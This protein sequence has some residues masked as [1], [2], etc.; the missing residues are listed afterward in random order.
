MKFLRPRSI[1]C[2][3][4][5]LLAGLFMPGAKAQSGSP[6]VFA[7]ASLK[8]ALDEAATL[9]AQSLGRPT[10]RI[11][12]AG[13]PALARQI[14]QGAP[15]DV[16]ISADSDWMDYLGDRKL[17]RPETRGDLVG[18]SI[19]IVAPAASPAT[20]PQISGDALAD[21]LGG[22]RLAIADVNSV[23]AGRYTKAALEKLGAWE[24]VKNRL[25]QSE[26]VRA[27]LLF[28]ARG[29]APLGV[30]YRTDAAAEPRVKIIAAPP[31]DSHPPII[32]PAAVTSASK[33]P[34]AAAFLAFLRDAQA[35]AVF[36][37]HGFTIPDAA[38]RK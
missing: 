35:G 10:P 21:A 36:E 26:N 20:L 9:Y 19:V 27:A 16:F 2:A 1:T 30:V 14:M 28:V 31:H 29:E 22:G 8:N 12:Y 17:I 13:S 38:A 5:L 4:F 6:V 18:N 32:Y 34:D 37:K 11:S 7:A 33:H 23:P 24:A 3:A 15:A 25:A